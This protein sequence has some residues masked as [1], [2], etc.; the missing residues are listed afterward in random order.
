MKKPV[1]ILLKAIIVASVLAIILELYAIWLS[2]R[3]VISTAGETTFKT[4]P[5]LVVG[6]L[7]IMC[8]IVNIFILTILIK[9]LN[10]SSEPALKTPG[11]SVDV[12]N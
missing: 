3:V 11:D 2:S 8:S 5:L 7:V 4:P 6:L 12:Q 9:S 1:I 10:Q